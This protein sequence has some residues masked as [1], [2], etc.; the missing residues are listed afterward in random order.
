MY[1]SSIVQSVI[2]DENRITGYVTEN[3]IYSIEFLNEP[4]N[5]QESSQTT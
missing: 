3:S 1:R 4:T 5:S 2:R